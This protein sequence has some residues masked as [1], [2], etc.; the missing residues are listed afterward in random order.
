VPIITKVVRLNPSH[1]WRGVL[2]TIIITKVVRLNPSHEWRG[3]LDTIIITKV[4]RLNP[5]HEWRGV[6]DTI[7]YYVIK[8]VCELWQVTTKP[9]HLYDLFQF[10]RH[11]IRTM[12]HI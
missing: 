1:E 9:V 12:I 5:S 3:V 8:F 4:V 11:L 10:S 2:D 7:L 6:L